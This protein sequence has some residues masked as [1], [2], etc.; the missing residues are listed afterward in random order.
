MHQQI[1]FWDKDKIASL[2][3]I[4]PTNKLIKISKIITPV[5]HLLHLSFKNLKTALLKR[6]KLTLRNTNALVL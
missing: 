4:R 1:T 3:V 2:A 5:L 6:F